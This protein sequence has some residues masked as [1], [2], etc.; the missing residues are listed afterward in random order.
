LRDFFLALASLLIAIVLWLQI[1]P[2]SVPGRE[3]E[4]SVRLDVENLPAGLAVIQ[5]PESVKVIASGTAQALE[6]LDSSEFSATIDLKDASVGEVTS[7]VQVKG[8]TRSSITARAARPRLT[9]LVDRISRTIKGISVESTGL[10]P[11]GFTYDSSALEPEEVEVTGPT[12][13]VQKVAVVRAILDLSKVRPGSSFTLGLE[14]MDAQ[15]RPVTGLTLEPSEVTA[16]PGV[17]SAPAAKRVFVNA[18]F[19]GQLPFGATVERYQVNP[20]QVELTGPS[21]EL[22]GVISLNTSPISLDALTGTV[23]REVDLIIPQNLRASGSGK[24]KVLLVIKEAQ[25]QPAPGTSP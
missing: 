8:P 17:N 4:M 15:G 5:A 7:L 22:A 6:Q 18:V 16:T 25:P 2:Q 10:P 13:L 23:E 1:Q 20:P 12:R 24:V 14:P 19:N 21:S 9:L 3:R 11:T